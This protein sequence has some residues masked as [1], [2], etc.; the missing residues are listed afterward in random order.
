MQLLE[1]EYRRLIV[2]KLA[3]KQVTEVIRAVFLFELV[4]V[5]QGAAT[6]ECILNGDNL[7]PL[8]VRA[9]YATGKR[10]VTDIDVDTFVAAT[11]ATVKQLA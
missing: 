9:K 4:E 5:K 6:G 10:L 2:D 11:A 1:R 3:H 7:P 8:A